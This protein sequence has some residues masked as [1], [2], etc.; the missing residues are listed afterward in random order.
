MPVAPHYDI[1]SNILD[2][3]A[4]HDAEYIHTE[5][6]QVQLFRVRGMDFE[7]LAALKVPLKQIIDPPGTDS[8][9]NKAM[10]LR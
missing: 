3:T 6:L 9:S 1:Q 4:G 10:E 5:A 2:L 7:P 8:L